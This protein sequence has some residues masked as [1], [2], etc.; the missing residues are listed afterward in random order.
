V[1]EANLGQP[2]KAAKS[3]LKDTTPTSYNLRD[4]LYMSCIKVKQSI[5]YIIFENLL[6]QTKCY[7][8]VAS[9]SEASNDESLNDYNYKDFD[10]MPKD[11]HE[12][13][14][15]VKEPVMHH[16]LGPPEDESVGC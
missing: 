11:N 5:L 4:T 15:L 13:E 3:M 16:L 10:T 2:T 6:I 7:S 12:N 1:N 9:E 14:G 8:D